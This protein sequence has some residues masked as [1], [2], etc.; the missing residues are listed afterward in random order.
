MRA[1]PAAATGGC[2]AGSS[3]CSP[4]S[5]SSVRSRT[6]SAGSRGSRARPRTTSS[7]ASR[8]PAS[9]STSSSSTWPAG[10]AIG[11][12]SCRSAG[13]TAA[14]RAC[15]RARVWPCASRGTSSGSRS[16]T[17][18]QRAG[19]G[20]QDVTVQPPL[21]RLGSAALPIVAIVVFVAVVVGVIAAAGDTLGYDFLAYY[22]AA[23]RAARRAAALRHGLPDGRRVRPVLL[24]AD[25]PAVHPAVRAPVRRRPAIWTWTALLIAAFAVGVAVLPVARNV[26]WWIV[27][28]AGLSWPFVYSIKLGQVGPILFLL[29]AIGWRWLDD[30]IRLGASAA[31]GT[32]IKLQPGLLFVWAILT[33]RWAAVV[34]GAVVL[35]VLAVVA[36]VLGG[37]GVWSDFVTLVRQVSDPITT[38]HNFTPGAIAYQ[39]GL[40]AS[41]ASLLQLACTVLALAAVVLAARWATAEASYLVAVIASQL[42]LA[43]PVGPLRDAA[44][45]AG[46]LPVRRRPL[47]GVA[48]PAGDRRPARRAS[49]RRSSTRSSFAVAPG[50]RH[51]GSGRGRGRRPPHDGHVEALA[52]PQ[53]P[54]NSRRGSISASS[55]GSAWSPS[56]PSSTGCATASSTPAA[57]TS[58]TWPTPSSTAGR[59]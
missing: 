50:G 44:P 31:L 48:D 43:D 33:R 45:A 28:L 18:R 49:R 23:V 41:A 11:W 36:T 54:R 21:A 40:S 51:R 59:G 6:P 32:A 16:S 2:S 39:L 17:G 53:R 12:R 55:S 27:L 5:G 26:R 56:R 9:S 35:V 1:T 14:A 30:P 7:R 46:R 34:A 52:A 8:S 25:L 24:P 57:A 37:V 15:A 58:S 22:Q 20:I 4:R 19:R 10:A 3:T 47:V 29:F 42:H 38:D 13:T